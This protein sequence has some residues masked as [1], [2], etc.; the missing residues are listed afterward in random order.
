MWVGVVFGIM[1]GRVGVVRGGWEL[2]G[3]V[4]VGLWG[5]WWFC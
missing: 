5:G 1:V 4:V 2:G 3:V